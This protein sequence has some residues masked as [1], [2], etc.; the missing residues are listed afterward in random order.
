MPRPVVYFFTS[1]NHRSYAGNLTR[2]AATSP[3][4]KTLDPQVSPS[5]FKSRRPIVIQWPGLIHLSELVWSH[6]VRPI[7]IRSNGWYS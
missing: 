7:N 3:A 1:E 2:A 5:F 4:V 6:L